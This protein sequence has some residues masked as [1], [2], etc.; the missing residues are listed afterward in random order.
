MDK[1]KTYII[2]GV[3]V[4]LV[5]VGI[6]LLVSKKDSTSTNLTSTLKSP[7]QLLKAVPLE[8]YNNLALVDNNGNL[9]SIPFPRGMIIMWHGTTTD[10]PDGWAPC[11]GSIVNGFQTP[12]LRG[13]FLVG[14]NTAA[15]T[16][17]SFTKYEAKATADANGETGK[18]KVALSIPEMPSHN[19][20]IRG[21]QNGYDGGGGTKGY[22]P[23]SAAEDLMGWNDALEAENTGGDANGNTVP[24]ENR[25]PFYA[26]VFII[27]L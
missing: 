5:I 26:M 6:I 8:G 16:N 24:H 23:S 13:R 12:D 2:I 27:K 10:I 22:A 21:Y 19:H 3:V 9:N 4:V 14:A 20:R 7:S 18:E 15:N 11:D 1:Q 25:P 17:P